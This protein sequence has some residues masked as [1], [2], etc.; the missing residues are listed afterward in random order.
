MTHQGPRVPLLEVDRLTVT[1]PGPAGPV[2]AVREVSLIVERG[3]MVGL[4]GES[5]AGKSLTAFA[6]PRLLPV[7]VRVAGGRILLEGDD[8]LTFSDSEMRRVRGRRVAMV[9]Q[10]PTTALNPVFTIGF[11][12]AE[13]VRAHEPISRR[14]ARARARSL[15]GRVALRGAGERLGA[16]PH[17]LSGGE[18]QRVVLA[19]ALAC[20]PDLLLADEPTTALDVTVQAQILE[21]LR[22][23]RD[24]LGLAVLLITHDLAVVAETCER[25]LVMYAGQIVER[26]PAPRLFAHPAHPYTRD[27]LAAALRPQDDGGNESAPAGRGE[28]PALPGSPPDPADLPSGC[29][30]HPRC[31]QVW[32]TCCTAAPELWPAGDE[33][34]ARCLLWRPG[35]AGRDA[36]AGARPVTSGGPG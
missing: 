1:V 7:G 25:V 32:A 9:F 8:L 29:P 22:S 18:R 19:M 23:L 16:Y 3:E 10:E 31:R 20:R 36:E 34:E 15:L 14:E 21:L 11:Q 24:E 12:V 35:R 33:Q 6:V 13:A 27:L 4:V 28:L 5:G 26:A 17:E 30:Y 2:A